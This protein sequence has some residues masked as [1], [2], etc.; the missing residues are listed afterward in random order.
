MRIFMNSDL[1]ISK[2]SSIM[3]Q[4]ITGSKYSYRQQKILETGNYLV[5]IID[6]E[7]PDLIINLGDTFDQH[8]LTSYDISIA[9]E[10]FK[11]FRYLS[12]PHLVLV[13]N[14]EMVNYEF[15]AI[16]ILSNID[17]IESAVKS[18]QRPRYSGIPVLLKVKTNNGCYGVV[19]EIFQKNNPIIK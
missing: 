1:H 14:H 12:I 19:L 16:D 5:D 17:N 8:T 15:N 10:F 9:S 2:T 4:N 6:K 13:G 18:H 3:P 7:K 11:C